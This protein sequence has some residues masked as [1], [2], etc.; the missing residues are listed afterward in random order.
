MQASFFLKSM[1]FVVL[2]FLDI[3]TLSAAADGARLIQASHS[4]ETI[5]ITLVSIFCTALWPVPYFDQAEAARFV[6]KILNR[7]VLPTPARSAISSIDSL[8]WPVRL[9]SPPTTQPTARS[10]SV[11]WDRMVGGITLE[12]PSIRFRN[13]RSVRCPSV[14]GRLHG[15]GVKREET[16]PRNSETGLAPTDLWL[17]LRFSIASVRN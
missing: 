17:G 9:I 5:V 13:L 1:L 16:R 6:L 4:A 12:P 11:K 10:P 2:T 8:Q 14:N 7:L 3:W 15:R